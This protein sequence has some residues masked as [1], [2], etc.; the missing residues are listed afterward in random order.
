MSYQSLW[1]QFKTLRN[2]LVNVLCTDG[3]I[4]NGKFVDIMNEYDNEYEAIF[5]ESGEGI[6]IEIPVNEVALVYPVR[7]V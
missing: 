4:V 1:K 3:Q 2:K 6:L 7:T 5:L